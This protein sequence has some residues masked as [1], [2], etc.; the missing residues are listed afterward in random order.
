MFVSRFHS[1]PNLIHTHD[2]ER[3]TTQIL[4]Y[5]EMDERYVEMDEEIGATKFEKLPGKACCCK[6]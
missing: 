5:L 4:R 6:R 1:T 2:Y 3:I